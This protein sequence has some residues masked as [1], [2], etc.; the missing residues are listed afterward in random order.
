[1]NVTHVLV[2]T[3]VVHGNISQMRCT[4]LCEPVSEHT[5]TYFVQTKN[6]I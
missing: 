3:N 4:K 6:G 2:L 5:C 1:M